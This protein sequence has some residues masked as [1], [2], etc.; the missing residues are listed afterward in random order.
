MYLY[1]AGGATYMKVVRQE[2]HAFPYSPSEV[3][4]DEFILLSKN[5]DACTML[6]KQVQ[7]CAKLHSVRPAIPEELDAFFPNVA[8]GERWRFALRLYWVR[9]FQRPFHLEEVPGL[10]WKR[11]KP[12]QGFS[13]LDDAD[14]LAMLRHLVA[15]NA[16]LIANIINFAE[17]PESAS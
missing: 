2:L 3:S 7:Y 12:V 8:A 11:Y 13:K 9:K 1:K 17:R 15:T 4:E 5:R 16:D 6:E 14:E 10:N